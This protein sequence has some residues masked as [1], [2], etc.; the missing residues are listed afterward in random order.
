[1]SVGSIS[2][3]MTFLYSSV[4]LNGVKRGTV[5]G[6]IQFLWGARFQVV[7]VAVTATVSFLLRQTHTNTCLSRQN[8]VATK[9]TLVAAPAND[10][11][12]VGYVV[13]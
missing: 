2:F 1:M 5:Y 12:I 7:S 4:Y 13:K 3:S 10:K 8:F 6:H 9:M 11:V